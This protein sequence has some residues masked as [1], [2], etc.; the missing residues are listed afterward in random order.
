MCIRDRFMPL[1]LAVKKGGRESVKVGFCGISCCLR[2]P[3]VIANIAAIS[4]FWTI[5]YRPQIRNEVV[6]VS[7]DKWK[8]HN[9]GK[10]SYLVQ[11]LSVLKVWVDVWIVPES[12]YFNSFLFEILNRVCST[13]RTTD[14]KE[15]FHV[16]LVSA[17][18]AAQ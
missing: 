5:Y 8:I 13:R 1:V 4:I 15:N 17:F 2:Q 10:P 3:E 16:P 9:S 12:R 14:V 7:F 11:S 18:C 6:D